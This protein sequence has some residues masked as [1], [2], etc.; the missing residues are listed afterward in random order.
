MVFHMGLKGSLAL[1]SR[2]WGVRARFVTVGG[3]SRAL[4]GAVIVGVV[5]GGSCVRC[6][7]Q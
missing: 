7:V 3:G 1:C 6:T 5:R 2:H 4:H